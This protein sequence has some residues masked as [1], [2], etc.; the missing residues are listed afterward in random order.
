MEF[1]PYTS[2][3]TK[4]KRTCPPSE[5]LDRRALKNAS[6]DKSID[7]ISLGSPDD[8]GTS[9]ETE[10]V[11]TETDWQLPVKYHVKIEVDNDNV[12]DLG[13]S[14]LVELQADAES[15]HHRGDFYW[16]ILLLIIGMKIWLLDLH[17]H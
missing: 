5:G 4:K 13:N 8:S 1:K 12:L 11:Q 2:C 3:K 16:D 15:D 7:A 6:M 9:R 17:G 10:P 14:T